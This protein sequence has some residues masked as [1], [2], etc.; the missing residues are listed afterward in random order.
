VT[1]DG[2]VR[3]AFMMSVSRC[4]SKM[5]SLSPPWQ[6]SESCVACCCELGYDVKQN[7]LTM[8]LA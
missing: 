5:E 8:V 7:E 3:F 4:E 6:F 2:R 1:Y